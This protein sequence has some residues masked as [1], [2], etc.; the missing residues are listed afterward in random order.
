MTEAEKACLAIYNDWTEAGAKQISES[1]TKAW[2]VGRDIWDRE[3]YKSTLCRLRKDICD[4]E[5][6]PVHGRDIR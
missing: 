5:Y 6:C 3:Q 4:D 1:I 2:L